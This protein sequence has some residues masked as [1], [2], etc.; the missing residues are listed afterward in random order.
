M[1]MSKLYETTVTQTIDN[2]HRLLSDSYLKNKLTNKQNEGNS[3]GY[4]LLLYS[5]QP[6]LQ[7]G[8]TSEGDWTMQVV[9]GQKKTPCSS[10]AW[11]G[12]GHAVWISRADPLLCSSLVVSRCSLGCPLP[13][14]KVPEREHSLLARIECLKESYYWG[15]VQL[16]NDTQSMLFLFWKHS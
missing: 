14:V 2:V 1:Q 13:S 6:S 11:S 16:D 7:R 12:L 15:R 10:W 3:V 9:A 4:L 5:I 8:W